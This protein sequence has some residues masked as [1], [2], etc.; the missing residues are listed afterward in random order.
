VK[1]TLNNGVVP[2]DKAP[3]CTRCIHYYIT[4]DVNFPY[5]CRA[6]GFK[7]QRQPQLDVLEASNQPCLAF[8]QRSVKKR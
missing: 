5:G 3:D 1:P 4:Y 6:L 2:V 8:E 7:S